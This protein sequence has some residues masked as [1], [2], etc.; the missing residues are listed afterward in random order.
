MI[1][2]NAAWGFRETPL[3]KQLQITAKMGLDYLELGIAGHRNDY[4]QLDA[5]DEIL[6]RVKELFAHYKIKLSYASA[7]ND[8]TFESESVCLEELEKLKKAIDIAGKLAISNVRIFAGF[9]PAQEVIGKRWDTM[10]RC[11]T[12]TVNHAIKLGVNVAVE[13]H[14]GVEAKGAGVRHFHSTSSQPELLLKMIEQLPSE[15]KIVFDPANLGAVGMN[16]DEII[17][18][19]RKLKRRIAYMHLKDFKDLPAGDGL[20]LP[21]ACG[22]GNLN[23]KKLMEAFAEF[24]G[25]GVIE[26]ENTEDIQE[27]LKRSLAFLSKSFS[28]K[29]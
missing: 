7:S 18:L 21:C 14:G 5:G 22:E 1:F 6:R 10:I 8:F 9:S 23:W 20:L 2:G 17:A 13:T 15:T 12:E 28:D 25:L 29:N 4:V 27:G 16:E 3:E 19:Y 26:Y 11:L 24:S